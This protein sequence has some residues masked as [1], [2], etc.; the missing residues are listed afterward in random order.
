MFTASCESSVISARSA[1]R[2]KASVVAVDS[3]LLISEVLSTF[4]RPTS[5]FTNPAGE[6]IVLFV[7]VCVPVSVATVESISSVIV[8]PES[9]YVLSNPV[10]ATIAVLT[11]SCASSVISEELAFRSSAACVAVET[12]LLASEVLSTFP[13]PTS[14]LTIPVG[15]FMFGD[16]SI[17][18]VKV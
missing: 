10:P 9:S 7:S 6:V 2:A 11:A 5:A 14:A 4:A 16:V 1:L 13:R 3:G 17:L 15:V 18:F 8:L 12:G